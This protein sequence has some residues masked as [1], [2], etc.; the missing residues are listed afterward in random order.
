MG[1]LLSENFP[2]ERLSQPQYNVKVEKDAYVRMR[3]GIRVAVDVY[4]PDAPGKFPVL[5]ASS[6]YIKDLVYLPPV[7]TYHNR[8]TNDINWF[9]QRGYVYVNADVRGTGKSEGIWKFHSEAE[10]KD[11]YDLIEWMAQQPWSTGRVGM[12]GESYFGWTQWFAATQQPPHLVT[13]VPFDAG[14]DMYRDVVYHGGLLGMGFLTWWHFNL[15]ANHI[16]D[17]PGPH[18]PELMTWDMVY[19]VLNHPTYD[20]FW[21]ERTVDF[22]H[23]TVP[24]YGIGMWH[25]IGLHLRGNLR[26]FEE[27]NSPKKLLVCWGEYVGDEMAIFNSLEMRL[28]MLRWYDHWLKDNDTGM[29]KEPP[30]KI[31]VRNSDEGYRFEKEWPLK[32]AQYTPFYLHPGPAGAVDSLNDG[33]LSLDSPDLEGSS[34][35]FEYPNPEW[36][37]WSGIGTAKFINGLPNPA[38]KILTFSSEPLK[39]DLEVTGPITLILYASSTMKDQDIY[40]RVVDQEPDPLQQ[41]GVIPPKG[42]ILTRGWLKA[43]HREKDPKLSKPYQPYYTHK[44]PSPIEPGKV[45]KYEVDVWPT[46]NLF[47]KGHR[48]RIDLSNGDSPAF[49]FGG[50]HYGLKLGKDTLYHDKDH[51]SH[52]ILPVIPR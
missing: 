1:S 42:K 3:D 5:Y 2:V 22:A 48:I 28:E 17:R 29:M 27:L 6:C 40:L 50:H 44:N 12:I 9:V 13:I 51:P 46:S 47:R 36:S 19:E 32:R 35:T 52:V 30:V 20:T 21:E 25:K 7:T 4:R 34:F 14:A 43:S 18:P 24:V 8:E 41:R 10:Q 16:F 37:G 33:G 39:E 23:I 11:H 38:I 31:A 49:D 45:Y 15:R 26:G